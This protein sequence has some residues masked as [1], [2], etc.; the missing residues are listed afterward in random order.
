VRET[1]RLLQI[2]ID[3][4]HIK[5]AVFRRLLGREESGSGQE[6]NS[7]AEIFKR[8]GAFVGINPKDAK[9]ISGHFDTSRR[10]PASVGTEHRPGVGDAGRTV[11]IE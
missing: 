8:V 10:Y 2:W 4:A 11:E 1:V 5:G 7:I 9:G 6:V 3:N